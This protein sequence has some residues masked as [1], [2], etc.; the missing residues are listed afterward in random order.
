MRAAIIIK[1]GKPEFIHIKDIPKPTPN[2]N[3]VLVKVHAT[4][5]TAGDVI[6]RKAGFLMLLVLRIF[7]L[8]KKTIPGTEFAGIIESVGNKVTQFKAGDEIF[9]T[10]TGLTIGGASEFICLPETWKQGVF[11]KKPSNISF[12]ESASSVV[13]GMTAL[14]LLQ[15]A[16]IQKG[17]K[18]LIYGASGSVGTFA[19]QLAKYFGAEVTGV[20]STKNL[21]L[22]ESIGADKVLD[23]TQ[24]E[25]TYNME[26]ISYDVVFDAVGK[27]KKG[28]KAL[29]K[30]G[31]FI[32]VKS[33]TDETVE[34]LEIIR[35]LIQEGKL[36][37]IIDKTFRLEEIIEAHEYVE[38]G[39]K[40]GNVVITID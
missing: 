5:V 14:H 38:K 33:I 1:Q 26:K 16:K 6:M 39:H 21:E 13:G 19:V 4:T 37:S 36:K 12:E 40:R 28:K 8:K 25:F 10:T 35:E 24:K 34:G 20:S 11:T 3:E 17:Y 18:I 15:K 2:E 9:G 27:L 7:G 22:I 23:Y 30:D 29:K 32:T 31:T